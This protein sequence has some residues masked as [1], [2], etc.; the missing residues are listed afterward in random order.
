MDKEIKSEMEKFWTKERIYFFKSLSLDEQLE[1]NKHTYLSTVIG[2]SFDF[3][4][5]TTS[6]EKQAQEILNIKKTSKYLMLSEH[7]YIKVPIDPR[8]IDLMEKWEKCSLL[9]LSQELDNLE[10]NFKNG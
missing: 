4:S 7:E 3:L 5:K 2:A 6:P 9:E 10:R 1:Y 8:M